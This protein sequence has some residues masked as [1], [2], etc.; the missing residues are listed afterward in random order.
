MYA[1]KFLTPNGSPQANNT[2]PVPNLRVQVLGAVRLSRKSRRSLTPA[3]KPTGASC[4]RRRA[5]GP[6]TNKPWKRK[7]GKNWQNY[8]AFVRQTILVRF[9][10]PAPLGSFQRKKALPDD[11]KRSE[12][13]TLLTLL[14]GAKTHLLLTSPQSATL[15]Y[16]T[17]VMASAGFPFRP[18]TR[19]FVC[20]HIVVRAYQSGE[21]CCGAFAFEMTGYL[22]FTALQGSR[23]RL[24]MYRC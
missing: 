8:D 14:V 13:R 22:T 24:E 10:P 7:K 1:P 16:P 23:A 21:A 9:S 15:R 3:L 19:A 12:K 11:R 2:F 20:R 4:D 5:G 18:T 6:S 17:L